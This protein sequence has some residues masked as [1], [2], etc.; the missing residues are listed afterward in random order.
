MSATTAREQPSNPAAGRPPNPWLTLWAMLVGFFMIL[1][2]STIVAVAN[3]AIMADLNIADYD[4]VI[5]V[6]SAYLL[7]YAVPLLMA[8][9]L[10]DRFGPKKLYII[11]LVVFT[12]ASLWCGLSGSIGMLVAAR[13][14]QGIGAALLTP[15]TLSTITQIFPAERRGVALSAWGATA[16]VATLI[17]PLAGGVLV[18]YLGWSWIFF[19]NVPVG[20]V[21]LVL[22]VWL[23]PDLPTHPHRFDVLGVVLSGAGLFLI[24]FGLQEGQAYRWQPWI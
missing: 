23:I 16:G 24:V 9:R 1:V 10:G 11:G 8:G 3:P 2:D 14:V 13:V 15:Q 5:W 19:V 21:G 20:I 12:G 22:A 17:G 4:T 18:D 6:T 7:A